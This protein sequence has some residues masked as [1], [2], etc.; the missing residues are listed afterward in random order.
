[1]DLNHGRAGYEPAALPT[2]LWARTGLLSILYPPLCQVLFLF[3]FK[4][5]FLFANLAGQRNQA[6]FATSS[7]YL[8][9][10]IF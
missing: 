10:N 5:A 4:T 7:K 3:Q 6:N 2:E 8:R 1:M 9:C